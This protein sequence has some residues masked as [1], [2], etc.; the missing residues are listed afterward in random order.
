LTRAATGVLST[1][2]S[3]LHIDGP[4]PYRAEFSAIRWLSVTSRPGLFYIAIGS[5]PPVFV[6]PIV[7]S[8]LGVLRVI[9]PSLNEALYA[10]LYR[11]A[12]G[13]VRCAG[14][15]ADARLSAGPCP[16]CAAGGG[17]LGGS[18]GRLR[19]VACALALVFFSC[20]VGSYYHLSRR[21]VREAKA[22]GMK[23]FLY[24]PVAEAVAEQDLSRHH[25][26]AGCYAPLNWLDQ[27]LLGSEGPGGGGMTW[28]LSK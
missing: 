13:L 16:Q 10:E 8:L 18:R 28:G 12:G 1:D 5:S 15:G 20:Y 27:A 2:D 23:G 19:L 22:Y 7:C 11:R 17:R 9:R 25:A 26:R 21:G 4:V 24:V 3:G 6:T 14:C